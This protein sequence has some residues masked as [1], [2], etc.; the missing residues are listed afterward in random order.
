VRW[1][2]YSP[3]HDS[4]VNSEDLHTPDLL[5]E[6]ESQPSSI[7]TLGISDDLLYPQ[8][9]C[10]LSTTNSPAQDS[11]PLPSSPWVPTMESSLSTCIPTT[12]N[13]TSLEPLFGKDTLTLGTTGPPGDLEKTLKP[14]TSTTKQS[15]SVTDCP[16]Y[17]IFSFLFRLSLSTSVRDPGPLCPSIT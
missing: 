5:A 7:R 6:F 1:K 15:W 10:L 4:W 2:G 14:S 12:I 13:S 16:A 11:P 9:P 17:F 3:A 8:P